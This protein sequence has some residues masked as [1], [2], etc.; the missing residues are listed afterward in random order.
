MAART[1][2]HTVSSKAVGCCPAVESL[3]EAWK[4]A[5]SGRDSRRP[6]GGTSNSSNSHWHGTTQS[7]GVNIVFEVQYLRACCV[8]V[9]AFVFNIAMGWRNAPAHWRA[10]LRY[11]AHHVRIP[12]K[13]EV[14][15]MSTRV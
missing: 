14:R 11:S 6:G 1:L 7:I 13:Q 10:L 2:V 5:T 4:E 15:V 9:I 12:I 8:R 3:V